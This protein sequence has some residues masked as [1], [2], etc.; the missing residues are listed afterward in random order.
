MAFV[1]HTMTVEQIIRRA[2][3]LNADEAALQQRD[4]M[5]LLDYYEALNE[6]LQSFCRTRSWWWLH[7]RSFVATKAAQSDYPLRSQARGAVTFTGVPASG[8]TITIVARTY[9]FTTGGDVTIS[10][11]T[12]AA[13]AATNLAA[14]I[15]GDASRACWA[16]AVGTVCYLYWAGDDGV[17]QTLTDST[18]AGDII[19]YTAFANHL[20]DF[21]SLTGLLWFG[22]SRLYRVYPE[23]VEAERLNPSDGAPVGYAMTGG[24]ATLR[25]YGSGSGAPGDIYPLAITYQ[26]RPSAVLPDGTGQ[27]DWPDEFMDVL[28]HAIKL[29]LKAGNWDEAATYGDQWFVRR[30]AELE[31]FQVDRTAHSDGGNLGGGLMESTIQMTLE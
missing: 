26:A 21:G 28:P 22:G 12:T 18:D 2:A 9:T 31:S 4:A 14:A 23:A 24:L 16:Q 30:L 1:A 19:A 11:P 15:N 27:L 25:I 10:T 20:T 17:G 5:A 29:L 13:L 8:D 7:R 6:F 3:R